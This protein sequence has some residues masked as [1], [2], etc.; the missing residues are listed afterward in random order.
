[1]ILIIPYTYILNSFQPSFALSDG[2]DGSALSYILVYNNSVSGDGCGS[3]IIPASSCAAGVCR[4][5][6][7][8][9]GSG[10]SSFSTDVNITISATNILGI[11]PPSEPTI[12]HST[13]DNST[14]TATKMLLY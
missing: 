4:H 2:I 8:Y 9:E 12:V 10:C 7:T 1:M 11:G 3:A 14:C 13:Y 6:F 5:S